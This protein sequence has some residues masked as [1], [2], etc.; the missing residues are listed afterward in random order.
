MINRFG[1]P[2]IFAIEYSFL[3]NPLN[4]N[5]ILKESWGY[6]GLIIKG[7]DICEYRIEDETKKYTYSL[8]HIADWLSSNLIYIIGYDPYPLPVK[9]D[10]TQE[11]ILNSEEQA[12]EEDDEEYYWYHAKNSWTM[13]HNWFSSRAG[14]YLASTY[15]RRVDNKIEISWDNLFF[16]E[17]KIIFSQLEGKA[18][19][20]IEEFK[21]IVFEFLNDFFY[22]LSKKIPDEISDDRL[23]VEN[24]W[25]KVK[26][27]EE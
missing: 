16:R 21:K 10:S 5:G 4:E 27:L 3:E 1:D 26:L 11:L 24:M 22:Q 9:G 13:R 25:K 7:N 6:F 19:I 15:F 8:I 18:L 14:S 17:N 2:N 23:H 20:S 12:P